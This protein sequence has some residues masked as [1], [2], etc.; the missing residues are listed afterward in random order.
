MTGW[1]IAGALAL[2]VV[3]QAGAAAQPPERTG[4]ELYSAACAACHGPDG[5]GHSQSRVGFDTPLPDF[6]DCSFATPEPDADWAAVV[7]H[8]GPVRAFDRMMPAFGEALSAAEIERVVTHVRGFCPGSGA[9]PRG[10]LNLP[11]ALATEKAFPE[12]EA[13]VTVSV[14]GD[15]AVSEWLYERRLGARS[16]WEVVV[17]LAAGQPGSGLGDIALALKHVVVHSLARGSILSAA[18]EVKLPTGREADG[19]GGGTTIFEPFV[20]FG[21]ILPADGFLQLQSGVE[22]PARSG[23]AKEAFWRAAIGRSFIAGGYGRTWSPMVEVLG[24]RELESGAVTHWDLV[25]QMQVTLSKRQHVMVNAGVRIP[26]NDRQSRGAA[27]LTY[28]LWDWFDGGFF[29][30]WR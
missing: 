6:T 19:R 16:Q 22:I 1:R 4:A 13:V 23:G 21:Q 9:W 24:A 27:L 12:N 3:W 25:P 30:G 14:D 8:G 26:A 7:A 29:D 18:A 28:L 10:E 17:P 2:V 11:R 5:R 15:A 20:A